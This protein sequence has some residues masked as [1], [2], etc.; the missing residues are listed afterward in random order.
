MAIAL[1]PILNPLVS[2]MVRL[3]AFASS[4]KLNGLS[5]TLPVALSIDTFVLLPLMIILPP[6][7]I[8]MVLASSIWPL[9]VMTSVPSTETVL[10]LQL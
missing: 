9:P 4:S 10:N 1:P 5:L 8:A 2:P 6:L 7:P 3:E